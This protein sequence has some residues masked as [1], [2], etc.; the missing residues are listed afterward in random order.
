M[1]NIWKGLFVGAIAGAAV[2]LAVDLIYGAGD[3]LAS[4]GREARRRAPEAADWAT[5]VT[6]EAR[7]KLRDA[8]LPE[9]VRSLAQ[10]IADSDFARQVADATAEA[11]VT[12][13]KVVRTAL[14]S[15]RD[16]AR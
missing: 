11:A 6:A 12:G 5:A 16:A 13:R 9:Q 15:V 8:D 1:R 3:Q 2:G 7:R 10:D 14:S 4:A